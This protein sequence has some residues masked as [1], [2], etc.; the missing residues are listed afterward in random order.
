MFLGPFA[1]SIIKRAKEQK[2]VDINLVN[3]R[4]FGIGKHRVVDDKPYGG[5]TGMVLR[6][7]VLEKAIESVKKNYSKKNKKGN[8]RVILLDPSGKTYNQRKTEKFTKISHLILVCGHY[9]GFDARIKEF[10]DE[11]ISIGDYI[12]TGGEI[13]AMIIT[14]SVVR[15][16]KGVLPEDATKFES[17]SNHKRTPSLLEHP[18]YT[19]PEIYKKIK[20]PEILFSGNHEEIKKW[21]EKE[22]IKTTKKTRPDLITN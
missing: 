13:P 9:E 21:R 2:I 16:I 1:H 18:Q 5:G 6:V 12:L 15:L 11:T 8:Q 19:R 14:D 10:V 3:I 7:D 20:V 22:A 17:F 4:E